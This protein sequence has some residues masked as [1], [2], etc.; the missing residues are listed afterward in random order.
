MSIAKLV[1]RCP[2][3][4]GMLTVFGNI[5]EYP[6][7]GENGVIFLW[8]KDTFTLGSVPAH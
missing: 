7:I 2:K 3:V 5:H 4:I 1:Q 6:M 8:F